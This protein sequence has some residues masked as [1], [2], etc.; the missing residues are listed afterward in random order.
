MFFKRKKNKDEENQDH[1][2][3]DP[4]FMVWLEIGVQNI[5]RA[6]LFYQNVFNIDVEIKDIVNG[7]IGT[8]YSKSKCLNVCLIERDATATKNSIKPTFFVDVISETLQKVELHGGKII[9]QPELLRQT[10]QKGESLIGANLIDNELGYMSEIS[11][12]EGNDILLYS[13]S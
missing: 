5:H 6:K 2:T 9:S 13:H 1:T 4:R 11:D 7:R 12:S 10:N 3:V 8:F